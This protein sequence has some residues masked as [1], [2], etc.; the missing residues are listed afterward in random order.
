MKTILYEKGESSLKVKIG[1]LIRSKDD[2]FIAIVI[3][4][5]MSE[6]GWCID[7]Y[8]YE[9]IILHNPYGLHTKFYIGVEV[10]LHHNDIETLPKGSKLELI[11]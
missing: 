11:V 5:L 9:C 3:N 4:R 2:R 8:D 7:E 1:D 6:S 10:T